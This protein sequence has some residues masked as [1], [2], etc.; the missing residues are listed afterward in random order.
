MGSWES[1]HARSRRSRSTSLGSNG[2]LQLET[3]PTASPLRFLPLAIVLALLIVVAAFLAGRCAASAEHSGEERLPAE[4]PVQQADY[5]AAPEDNA[6][7]SE[8][9][10]PAEPALPALEGAA[11]KLAPP[12]RL[13][14]STEVVDENGVIRGISPDGVNYLSYGRGEGTWEEG[15][16]SLVAVGDQIGTDEALALTDSWAGETGDGLY[17]F[18]PYYRDIR[19][20]IRQRDLRYINQETVMAYDVRPYYTGWPSFNTP[21]AAADAIAYVGFNMVNLASNHTLDFNVRGAEANLDV[22][23][24]HPQQATAGSYRSPED[25]ATVRL[26]ERG[27]LV[28]AFLAYSY[29][30]NYF[31]TNL[32]DDYHLCGFDKDAI[33]ADVARARQVS[34]AVIVSMHWGTEY[35]STPNAQQVEYAQFLADLDVDLVL[36]S[37]AHVVQPIEWVTG[38]ETGNSIPVV[39]GLSD[40]VSSYGLLDNVLSGLFTCKFSRTDEGEVEVWDLCWYPAIEWSDG[41]ETVRVRLLKDMTP[42]EINANVCTPD[43]ANDYEHIVAALDSLNMQ[44]QV[45]M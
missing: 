32:P 24:R 26:I 34:D 1:G 35:K 13:A 15:V 39:Y 10:E 25:R 23:D 4:A 14:G 17:D 41:S 5:E 40:I 12:E 36:G 27:G 37:H 20:N 42:E 43:V 28:F 9:A 45:I 8:P 16:V 29:G 33:A 21:E 22:W 11:P 19:T 30:D 2:F 6:E 18:C 38:P 31:Q 44:A 7:S 3:I